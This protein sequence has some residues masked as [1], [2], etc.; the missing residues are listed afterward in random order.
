MTKS[1]LLFILFSLISI[2]TYAKSCGIPNAVL[3]CSTKYLIQTGNPNYSSPYWLKGISV[4]SNFE[5]Y[6]FPGEPSESTCEAIAIIDDKN[7]DI[8]FNAYLSEANSLNLYAV[9]KSQVQPQ[10]VL[11]IIPEQV[12]EMHFNTHPMITTIDGKLVDILTAV[13]GCK[14][15]LK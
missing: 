8:K 10:I 3:I 15:T 14:L 9:A 2:K 6:E 4:S 12:V 7:T 13:Y 5:L 11:S 1:G